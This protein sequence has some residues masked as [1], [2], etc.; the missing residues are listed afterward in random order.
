M[1]TA[2]DDPCPR[3]FRLDATGDFGRIGHERGGRG[4]PHQIE[5]SVETYPT[6]NVGY[7]EILGRRIQHLHPVA[8]LFKHCG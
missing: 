8:L 2:H 1:N 4:N 3:S 6:H 7:A 5:G